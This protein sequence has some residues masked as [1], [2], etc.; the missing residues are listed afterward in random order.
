[1]ARRR[2]GQKGVKRGASFFPYIFVFKNCKEKEEEKKIEDG[3]Y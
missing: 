2:E 3:H 1:M